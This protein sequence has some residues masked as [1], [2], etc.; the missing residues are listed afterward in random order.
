MAGLRSW[1]CSLLIL[2]MGANALAKDYSPWEC[3]VVGNVDSSIFHF[4][5]C[6]NYEQM[7]TKNKGPDNRRCFKTPDEAKSS[8][9][10]MARRCRMELGA[11]T[12]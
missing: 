4:K 7:L 8:G 3:P 9:Y 11:L 12:H 6:P 1:V 5:G 2:L 10:R